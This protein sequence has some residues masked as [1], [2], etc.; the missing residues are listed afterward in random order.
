MP[1]S[2]PFH[3]HLRKALKRTP[4]QSMYSSVIQKQSAIISLH[5][6]NRSTTRHI[7]NTDY[8]QKT[9]DTIHSSINIIFPSLHFLLVSAHMVYVFPHS[10]CPRPVAF[11]TGVLMH[12]WP[13]LTLTHILFIHSS[14]PHSSATHIHHFRSFLAS[15]PMFPHNY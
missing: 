2:W 3:R 7:C 5:Q 1:S 13:F 8:R 6:Q 15:G 11:P 12:P 14:H 10:I 4:A 9:I